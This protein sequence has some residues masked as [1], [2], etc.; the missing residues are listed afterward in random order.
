[1]LKCEQ[2]SGNENSD[3]LAAKHRLVGGTERDLGLTVA[4][5]A[6][7]QAI[8]G[9]GLHH[10]LFDLVGGCQLTFGLVVFKGILKRFLIAVV[11]GEGMTWAAHALGVELDQ[12]LCHILGGGF[13]ARLGFFPGVAPH[14]G[15]LYE[16]VVGMRTDIFGDLVKLFGGQEQLIRAC[17][18]NAD[19][20]ARHTVAGQR[21]NARVATDTVGLVDHVVANLKLRIGKDAFR[22]LLF[23]FAQAGFC[24]KRQ[25]S[26]ACVGNE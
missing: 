16:T 1:M 5:V 24:G 21:F 6:A 23:L 8:H 13:C 9:N 7:E 19:V 4:H 26:H 12:L 10:V 22:I 14:F 17:V 20:V 2:G 25:G 3:L 18:G 11:R 15:E